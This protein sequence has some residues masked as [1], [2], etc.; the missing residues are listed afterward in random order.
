MQNK[1]YPF[2]M[3]DQLQQ[4]RRLF[5]KHRRRREKFLQGLSENLAAIY[6]DFKGPLA[7]KICRIFTF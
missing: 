4:G 1:F 6:W 5:Q 7:R 2:K 3:Q